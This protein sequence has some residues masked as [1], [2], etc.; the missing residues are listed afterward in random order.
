MRAAS[1]ARPPCALWPTTLRTRWL[2][3]RR[4]EAGI[5]QAAATAMRDL[6]V[7]DVPTCIA[8]YEAGGA[9]AA[10]CAARRPEADVA[11]AALA[12]LWALCSGDDARIGFRPRGGAG[13]AG[14][15][16]V[17]AVRVMFN[18]C[19]DTDAGCASRRDAVALQRRCIAAL[20]GLLRRLEPYGAAD[21]ARVMLSLCSGLRALA[22]MPSC[23]PSWRQ[24]SGQRLASSSQGPPRCFSTPSTHRGYNVQRCAAIG[25]GGG[26]LRRRLNTSTA[27]PPLQA[28]RSSARAPA[29]AAATPASAWRVSARSAGRAPARTA[30]RAA[31]GWQRARL[32]SA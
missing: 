25:G 15:G 14:G 17:G 16:R 22:S 7:G 12:G 23:L 2:V 1:L 28:L 9:A 5:V 20:L 24:R 6:C 32:S 21:A 8:L 4:P 3:L 30:A 10:V 26:P 27:A 19:A 29:A 18:L 11:A 13:A 31:G